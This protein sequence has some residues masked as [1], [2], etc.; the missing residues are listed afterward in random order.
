M[1][2]DG[3][4]ATGARLTTELDDLA[5]IIEPLDQT[6]GVAIADI[7]APDAPSAPQPPGAASSRTDGPLGKLV[8]PRF[9]AGDAVGDAWALSV[10]LREDAMHRPALPGA[11]PQQEFGL[12]AG[13]RVGLSEGITLGGGYGY[14]PNDWSGYLGD[15]SSRAGSVEA[16]DLGTDRTHHVAGLRLTFELEPS[17]TLR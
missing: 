6:P 16:D 3:A 15:T 2:D 14:F 17:P 13:V 9:G 4:L 10:G 7:A 1:A 8:G 12:G 5:D 11:G